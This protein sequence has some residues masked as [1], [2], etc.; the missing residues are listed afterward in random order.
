MASVSIR[1]LNLMNKV[2]IGTYFA[3]VFFTHSIFKKT[4]EALCKNDNRLGVR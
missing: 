2:T 4:N 1:L 3:I